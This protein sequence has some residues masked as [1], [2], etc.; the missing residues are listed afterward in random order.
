MKYYRTEFQGPEISNRDSI[1]VWQEKGSKD[2]AAVT[3]E[4]AREILKNH[5]PDPLPDKVR[6]EMHAVVGRAKKTDGK[7]FLKAPL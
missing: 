3:N 7:N 2:I 4:K 1:S 5:H 6:K